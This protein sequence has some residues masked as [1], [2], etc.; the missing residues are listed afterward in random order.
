MSSNTDDMR[1]EYPPELIRAGV[2]GKFASRYRRGTNAVLLDADLREEFPD[3][4][5]VNRA[6]REYLA[7]KRR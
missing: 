6:L 7:L 2:G 5:S 3:S 1:S 4:E